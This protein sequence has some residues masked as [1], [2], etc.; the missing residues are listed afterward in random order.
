MVTA[1]LTYSPAAGL[2][3]TCWGSVELSDARG[4][5]VG[6]S[7]RGRAG[8]WGAVV[9]ERS[10][11]LLGASFRPGAHLPGRPGQSRE[12]EAGKE[13]PCLS[14]MPAWALTFC[15]PGVAAGSISLPASLAVPQERVGK[16][17][18]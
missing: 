14:S 15:F 7:V 4:L 2:R 3:S 17:G 16:K 11:G 6:P 10:P 12:G 5:G 18:F 8:G 9:Q 1:P 13:S